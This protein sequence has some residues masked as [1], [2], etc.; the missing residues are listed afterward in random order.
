MSSS[1]KAKAE[2]LQKV[3]VD[4]EQIISKLFWC[5]QEAK[6]NYFDVLLPSVRGIIVENNHRLTEKT[7]GS[8]TFSDQMIWELLALDSPIGSE[9]MGVISYLLEKSNGDICNAYNEKN[10]QEKNY[11]K[12]IEV[13]FLNPSVFSLLV[14]NNFPFSNTV[15]DDICS[16]IRK[17]CDTIFFPFE[18]SS[19][20]L[21]DNSSNYGGWN[22]AYVEMKIRTIWLIDHPK[23]YYYTVESEEQKD[24]Y[25]KEVQ[26]ILMPFLNK[27][28]EIDY[29]NSNSWSIMFFPSEAVA[30]YTTLEQDHESGVFVT[31]M[32]ILISHDIPCYI[33]SPNDMINLRINLALWIKH[34]KIPLLLT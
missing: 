23:K 21:N 34:G 4:D 29:S 31:A 26:R 12:M 17:D 8:I 27:C 25:L 1:G 20:N 9:L 18:R 5:N 28:I 19:V 30:R 14:T 32:M 10:R 7:I 24:L 3:K 33:N 6:S 13:A 16:Q 15:N 22:L 2:L 11:V